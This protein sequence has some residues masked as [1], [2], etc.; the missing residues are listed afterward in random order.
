M[1]TSD[2]T[3]ELAERLLV[4]NS[5]EG[6]DYRHRYSRVSLMREY[7]RRAA[8]WAES[9]NCTS[10]W[11]FFDIAAHVDPT[12]R[13]DPVLVTRIEKNFE[14]HPA[15]PP[16]RDTSIWALQ[17]A[18]LKAISPSSIPPH[19]EDPFEPLILMYERGGGFTTEHGFVD[20]DMAGIPLRSWRDHLSSQ[21]IVELDAAT[22]DRLDAQGRPQ[23]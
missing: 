1:K 3:R 16:V 2:A 13:A 17:W 12:V 18:Q 21:P 4:A 20:V 5:G 14:A 15:W 6:S 8:R 7:L 19:L 22:L 10:E 23:T 11:P 9:L